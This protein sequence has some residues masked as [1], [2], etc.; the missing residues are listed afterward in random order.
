MLRGLR[1]W[2]GFKQ[3]TIT[4]ARPARTQ[5]TTK[6]NF[7]KLLNLAI[8]AFVG[9]TSLPLRIASFIG[10]AMSFFSFLLTILFLINRIFPAV[11]IFGYNISENPGTATIAVLVSFISGMLFFC[12]GIIGEYVALLVREVKR[13]PTAI[14]SSAIGEFSA[15]PSGL[16]ILSLA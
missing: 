12:L 7:F 5:G 16:N 3:T 10:I 9:Y 2:V 8:T 15:K 14:V 4:Y 1:S 6:Y 11:S 13:R